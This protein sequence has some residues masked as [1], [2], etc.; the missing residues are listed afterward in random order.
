MGE[1]CSCLPGVMLALSLRRYG[2]RHPPRSNK[3]LWDLVM[4]GRSRRA[5]QDLMKKDWHDID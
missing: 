5:T 1:G 4:R 3:T 2:V